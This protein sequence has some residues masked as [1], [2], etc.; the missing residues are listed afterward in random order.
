MKKTAGRFSPFTSAEAG[1]GGL[2]AFCARVRA[3]RPAAR[4]T[5]RAVRHDRFPRLEAGALWED[6]KF[7]LKHFADLER[8]AMV[9]DKKWQHGMAMFCTPFTQATIRYLIIPTL[10]RRGSGWAKRSGFGRDRHE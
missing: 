4:K 1:Q 5:A 7:D 3:T 8:L 9:G 2:R 6:V 10:L